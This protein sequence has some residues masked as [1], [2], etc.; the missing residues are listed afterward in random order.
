VIPRLSEN[1]VLELAA[2]NYFEVD[3]TELG[4]YARLVDEL[5]ALI[6]EL[7]VPEPWPA[8]QAHRDSGARPEPGSDPLNAIVR[9]CD[10][11]GDA[12][13][14]LSGKRVAL[15]DSIAIAG[16]PLTCGSA[17]LQGFTPR[18][19][20]VVT[21]RVL[22]AGGRIV[23][24]TNMD[25]LAFSGSGDTSCYGATLNPFD[26]TRTAGGSSSGAAAALHYDGIDVTLGTDQGGSIR[27]PAAWCG[28][29]GLKPTHGLVP[30]TGIVA[31]DQ[32]V[33]HVGPL[34]RTVRDL[35]LAL[36][37]IAGFDDSDPRQ[38]VRRDP[39]D[40][41]AAAARPADDLRTIR[42][43]VVDETLDEGATTDTA[44]IRATRD[45]IELLRTHG[46]HIV[47][48]SIPEHLTAGP[49]AFGAAFEGI[50]A[51][52]HSGGNGYQW[53]GRYWPEL[54]DGVGRGLAQHANELAPQVKTAL[55][56]GTYLRQRYWG[57]MYARAQNRRPS[58]TR[59][60]DRALEGVDVLVMPTSPSRPLEVDDSLPLADRVL[61]GWNVL[62]NTTPTDLTGHP[63]ISL[64][65][66]EAD[67]LPVGVMAVG[68]AWSEPELLRFAASVEQLV[69]WKPLDKE[70]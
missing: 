6:D 36:Q 37:V 32:T 60:Y 9:W 50:A 2:Q 52:L 57:A 64:P 25:D 41:V 68:R 24:V 62:G 27:L 30:Y 28:V 29:L 12:E 31:I 14:L 26:Q 7:D 13:G 18:S 22:Q 8:G 49:I 11:R 67:G 20:S 44:T 33:D 3:E 70:R 55:L 19:D 51:L 15:K 61:R 58:L 54:A 35:A 21:E 46:A 59:A 1:D 56:I 63:A 53:K 42:V 38:R 65:I 43:G 40:Y 4:E 69:G 47:S 45:A 10:V 16:I 48:R 39:D 17:M 66:A 5:L 23:A 34:A